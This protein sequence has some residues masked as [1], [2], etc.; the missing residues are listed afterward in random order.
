MWADNLTLLLGFGQPHCVSPSPSLR[1]L[2]QEADLPEP[3][4]SGFPLP[5]AAPTADSAPPAS[6]PHETK[7]QQKK[8]SH[9]SHPRKERAAADLPHL[10]TPPP[11]SCDSTPSPILNTADSPAL[12][13][14]GVAA[15]T[16]SPV[17]A[18][19]GVMPH[20]TTDD[21]V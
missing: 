13:G 3:M 11:H 2:L 12:T 14:K 7:K 15:S 21:Y 5:A 20:A 1:S 6:S 8:K 10:D 4:F 19:E 18:L 17:D 9:C 16:S